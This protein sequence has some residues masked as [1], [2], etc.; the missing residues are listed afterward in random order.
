MNKR[1]FLR[2]F[3]RVFKFGR[4]AFQKR[5]CLGNSLS[6]IPYLNSLFPNFPI[7][8]FSQFPNLNFRHFFMGN[9]LAIFIIC[10][11]KNIVF[12]DD[13]LH[14]YE[15]RKKAANCACLK[16]WPCNHQKVARWMTQLLPSKNCQVKIAPII[17]WTSEW[18]DEWMDEYEWTN[19]RWNGP[20]K[21]GPKINNANKLASS[22]ALYLDIYIQ[23]GLIYVI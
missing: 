14:K 10:W 11:I 9:R 8:Q 23:S 15:M 6:Q 22:W 1:V 5:V 19:V 2:V 21:T 18:M 7:S 4:T 16:T 20:K 3:L 13:S 17:S 12:R